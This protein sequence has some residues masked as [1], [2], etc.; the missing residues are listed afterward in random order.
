[1]NQPHCAGGVPP[2]QCTCLQTQQMLHTDR[3]AR[4]AAY[5]GPP[6]VTAADLAAAFP[7]GVWLVHFDA[8]NGWV[9]SSLQCFHMVSVHPPERRRR[10]PNSKSGS[11]VSIRESAEQQN[12]SSETSST[13]RDRPKTPAAVAGAADSGDHKVLAKKLLVSVRRAEPITIDEWR[14][15]CEDPLVHLSLGTN[16]S[17]VTSD[18]SL[19]EITEG[20]Y[21]S[22]EEEILVG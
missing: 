11:S 18:F 14:V 2:Q 1:M 6:R 17:A 20:R 8:V 19:G 13:L 3:L 22:P 5:Q 21:P 12:S 10:N 9:C 4:I 7:F 15:S 16:R